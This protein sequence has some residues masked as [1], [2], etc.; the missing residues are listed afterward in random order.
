MNCE[1]CTVLKEALD[2][3]RARNKELIET[4]TELVKPTPIV[5]PTSQ[6]TNT[7]FRPIGMTLTRRRAEL[8]RADRAAQEAKKGPHAARPDSE[9][10]QV[11]TIAQLEAELKVVETS[12]E[13]ERREA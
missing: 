5:Q 11:A 4:L 7:V 6:T 2:Y 9:L 10:I 12:P 13:E 8:E 3:E 1:T